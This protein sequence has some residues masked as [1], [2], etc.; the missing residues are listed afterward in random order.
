M[1][2]VSP[3]LYRSLRRGDGAVY[4]SQ[5]MGPGLDVLRPQLPP[6]FL[7]IFLRGPVDHDANCDTATT[8]DSGRPRLGLVE[9][10]HGMRE[11]KAL[12][13]RTS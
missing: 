12:A 2:E 11:A 5:H 4:G 6:V 13:G 1:K 9:E 3:R 7:L 10:R 8:K